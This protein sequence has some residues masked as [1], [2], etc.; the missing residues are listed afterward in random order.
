MAAPIVAGAGAVPPPIPGAPI[1]PIAPAGNIPAYPT[2][3]PK[4][5]LQSLLLVATVPFAILSQIPSFRVM[6]S[7]GVRSLSC[8]SATLNFT[9]GIRQDN[10]WLHITNTLKIAAVVCGIVALAASMPF[11]IVVSLITD[12][13]SETFEL[14]KAIYQKDLKKMGY[15]AVQLLVNGLVLSSILTGTIGLMCAAIAI[16]SC[17]FLGNV[18][19][20]IHR[21]HGQRPSFENISDLF[22][23][24]I[25]TALSLVSMGFILGESR[26]EYRGSKFVIK[27]DKDHKTY[28]YGQKNRV[29]ILEPGQEVTIEVPKDNIM[30]RLDGVSKLFTLTETPT[31]I[32]DTPQFITSMDHCYDIVVREAPISTS[33]LYQMPVGGQTYVPRQE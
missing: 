18:G 23:Y 1:A 6:G 14:G 7:L 16:N 21:T 10:K 11:L 28:V 8:L 33:E 19:F 25:L 29:A 32:S 26:Y 4:R 24:S 3:R 9:N 20:I 17:V 5:I 30:G 27:G 13:A 22:C 31:G 15:H 2:S 12:I